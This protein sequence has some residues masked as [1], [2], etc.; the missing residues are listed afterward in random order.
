MTMALGV[1]LSHTLA[2]IMFAFAGVLVLYETLRTGLRRLRARQ[3]TAPV[4]LDAG[5]L[6]QKMALYQESPGKGDELL[7]A[8]GL[9]RTPEEREQQVKDAQGELQRTLQAQFAQMGR[10]GVDTGLQAAQQVTRRHI[11]PT[12]DLDNGGDPQVP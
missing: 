1:L 2:W 12:G 9:Y 11:E 3:R 4:P 5:A 10:W 7:K 6:L 8:A